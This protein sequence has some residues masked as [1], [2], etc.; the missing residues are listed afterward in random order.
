[1]SE[2]GWQV[3]EAGWRARVAGWRV[4]TGRSVWQADGSVR[5]AK[6][7]YINKQV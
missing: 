3:G 1:M 7:R 6:A 5:Q 2:E 4:C